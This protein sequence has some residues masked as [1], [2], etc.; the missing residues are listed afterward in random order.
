M[1]TREVN[2]HPKQFESFN[3]NTPYCA[4]ISGVQGGKTYVG[5]YWAANQIQTMPE[6]GYGAIIAPT[7]KILAQSTLPKFFQEFPNLRKYYKEQK[8]EM[9]LPGKKTIYIRSAENPYSLEGMTLD[10]VWGDEAGAFALL[11]LTILRSR[12]AIKRG[13]IF[14]TTTPYNMGALYQT[15]YKPWKD[16]TDKDLSVFQWQ[17]IDN[18]YFPK[19]FFEKEK[20]RL[21]PEEFARRYM[22][23]FTRMQGLVYMLN[24]WHLID[25]QNQKAEITLAGIDW[26]WSNPAA[27]MVI[28][29]VQG[30][31]FI[32]D[33]WYEINKTTGQIIEACRTLQN[34]WG[35]NRF[36]ADSANP[37]KIAEANTNTGLYV[38]PYEKL[39]DS[40]TA[41]V[42][43]INGLLM[44]NRLFVDRK[45]SNTLAE[46]E[47]YQYPEPDDNGMIKKD[48][49]MPF[50][51]HLM[52]SMRYAIMGYQPA[53]R[54]RVPKADETFTQLAVRRLLDNRQ[55]NANRGEDY[56]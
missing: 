8:G 22:G 18:P 45:L 31:Y 27:I 35:I 38:L 4:A 34:K 20:A 5:T 47:T 50:N 26:G 29:L 46:F 56:I 53:H 54:A 33:E 1:E 16:G 42:S 48:E 13:K 2:L 3:F 17:S 37:E 43:Y 14:Y 19:D 51:N 55:I 25:W 52:D 15:F 40:L 10:W 21:R 7:Y 30:Q 41:G 9:N 28:K 32:I 49:P 23:E 39:K 36:Y 12:T 24:S 44:E 6:G 11:V